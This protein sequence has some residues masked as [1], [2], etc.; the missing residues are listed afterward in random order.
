MFR[1]RSD[2][3][4]LRRV[5]GCNSKSCV[6]LDPGKVCPAPRLI[7]GTSPGSIL[8]SPWAY[9]RGLPLASLPSRRP[10]E[11]QYSGC[12]FRPDRKKADLTERD[13][14]YSPGD[15][16][17][18]SE[19][20]AAEGELRVL[21]VLDREPQT[22]QRVIAR[23]TS[24]SVGTVN[25]ILV[26][27]AK[28]EFIRKPRAH[29]GPEHTYELTAAGRRVVMADRYR[30]FVLSMERYGGYCSCIT[31]LVRQAAN[32]GYR[33]L[34]L[35]GESRLTRQLRTICRQNGIELE[36]PEPD[37]DRAD[38]IAEKSLKQ[39]L[40]PVV[41]EYLEPPDS[42]SGAPVVSLWPLL[43]EVEA[44]FEPA[45]DAPESGRP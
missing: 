37:A 6:Q 9:P 27:L 38:E 23:S 24:L 19:I 41:S 20:T 4:I 5:E 3:G 34:H 29:S 16:S 8:C 35:I 33:G 44:A 7:L 31:D 32:D 2:H 21:Q 11:R 36:G 26:C 13:R 25:S 15:T 42:P 10:L 45:P 28:R 43:A 18:G 14:Q 1:P 17:D 12:L 22:K 40:L 39:N 30:R